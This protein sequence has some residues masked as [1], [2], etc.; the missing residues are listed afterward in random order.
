M[1]EN[2]TSGSVEISVVDDGGLRKT[3]IGFASWGSCFTIVSFLEGQVS[4]VHYFLL[5]AGE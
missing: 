2:T 4:F 3:W 5:G 1:L